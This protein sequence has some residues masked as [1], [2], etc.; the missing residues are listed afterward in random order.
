MIMILD[1]KGSIK[2]AIGLCYTSQVK[3]IARK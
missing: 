3:H 2:C 1:D